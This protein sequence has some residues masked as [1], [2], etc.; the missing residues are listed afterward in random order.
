MDG[1]L[2]KLDLNY[3]TFNETRIL[4]YVP[5]KETEIMTKLWELYYKIV[6]NYI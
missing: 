1:F 6:K 4:A 5:E 3:E 2:C